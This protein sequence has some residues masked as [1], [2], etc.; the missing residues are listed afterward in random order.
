MSSGGGRHGTNWSDMT[1][2]AKP[3]GGL[4]IWARV[5]FFDGHPS[6]YAFLRIDIYTSLGFGIQYIHFPFGL[7]RR[8]GG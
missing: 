3:T 2:W 6:L 7:A 1:F 5:F 8:G 4:G